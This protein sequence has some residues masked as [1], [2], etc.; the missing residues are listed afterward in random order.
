MTWSGAF[1]VGPG[2]GSSKSH[3]S[4][5]SNPGQ[6]KWGDPHTS[7]HAAPIVF[8][9]LL[10]W[11]PRN[12]LLRHTDPSAWRP[13]MAGPPPDV[14]SSS[15]TEGGSGAATATEVCGGASRLAAPSCV[16]ASFRNNGGALRE[17]HYASLSP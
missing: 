4:V 9:P 10:L 1:R 3:L 11:G 7:R 17:S 16:G 15:H 14:L 6:H 2:A 13:R 12:E 5:R 8:S